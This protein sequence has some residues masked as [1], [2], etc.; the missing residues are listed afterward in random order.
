MSAKQQRRFS[1]LLSLAVLALVAIATLLTYL[2]PPAQAQTFP[3]FSGAWT[4]TRTQTG[5]VPP[6]LTATSNQTLTLFQTAPGGNVVG[7]LATY[8]P[9]TP[10][11]WTSYASGTITGSTMAFTFTPTVINLPGGTTACGESLSLAL[12]TGSVT[13]ATVPSYHP[14]GGTSSTFA[15]YPFTLLG[16]QKMYGTETSGCSGNCAYII[17]NSIDPATGNIVEPTVD[18]ETA[19]PNKLSL[20]R[21]YN[22]YHTPTRL[23]NF[24]SNIV[25]VVSGVANVTTNYDL[26]LSIVGN[27]ATAYRADGQMLTFNLIGGVW[28][29]DSDVDMVL[30]N[31]S[32]NTW[33]ITNHDDSVETYTATAAVL[34]TL[35]TSRLNSIKTRNG[36]TQTLAYNGSN[37]LSTVTDSYGRTLTFNYT[38]GYLTS[39]TTP[40]SLV[41]SYGYSSSTGGSNDR[42]AS[43]S[44]NTSPATSQSFTYGNSSFPFLI[45]SITD[46]N[47]VAYKTYTYD[48]YGRALTSQTGTGANADITTV[49]YNDSVGTSTVTNALGQS[50]VNTFAALQG[51]NKSAKATRTAS[52]N[53]PAATST[54][55]YDSNGY[56][57]TATDWNGNKTVYT[58]N[59]HGDPTTIVEASGTAAARTTTIAYDTTFVH[60]PATI[61]ATGLTTGFSYDANG[62][63]LTRVLTDTTTQTIPYSTNGQTRTTNF[64]WNNFLPATV[65][66]PNGNTTTFTFAPDGALT[67]IQNALLQNAAITSHTGGGMPLTV[68]GQNGVTTTL[69][70]NQRNWLLTSTVST[71][72][73]PL[74]TTNSYDAVGNLTKVQQPDGSYLN[75]AYDTAYRLTTVTDSL[76]NSI[77]Y[78]LDAMGD[79]T[80]TAIKDPS[81]TLTRSL[82]ATFDTLGRA[83]TSVAGMSQTTTWQYDDNGNMTG[84]LPPARHFGYLY[85]QLDRATRM[86]FYSIS[87]YN[88]AAYDAQDNVT[89]RTDTLSKTTSYVFDGFGDRIQVT[90]PDT[91][92]AVYHYDSD[93]N[94]TQK[95]DAAGV[96]V[97]HTYDALD[98]LLTTTYPAS[99]GENVTHTYD[100]T[101]TGFTFGIGRLTSLTDQAGT[102][103]QAYDERGNLLTETRTSGATT[104]TT[105]YTYDAASRV[106]TITYPDTSVVTYTRDAMGKITSVTDK[107][108]GAGSPTTLASSITYKP[109]GPWSGFTYGNGIVETPT[110][111]AD[112][113]LTRLADAGTATVQDI[114]YVYSVNDQP[115]TATDNLTAGNSITNITDDPYGHINAYR[116]NGGTLTQIIY[117]TS[118]NVNNGSRKQITGTTYTNTSGTNQLATITTGGVTNTLTTSANGNITGFST[119]FGTAGVTTLAY[120]NANRLSSVSNSGGTLGSY[121]YEASG[122]RFSKTVGANTT[123]FTHAG[124]AVLAETAGGTATNYIYL[125][126]R[127]LAML[128]GSTFTYL[129][130]DNLGTPRVATNASQTVSWKASYLPFG[131]TLSTT[132]SLTQNLRFPGQYFDAESGFN[133]NGFRDYVPTL[134]RYLEA[135]PIGIYPNAGI[136]NAGMNPYIYVGADPMR[137]IDPWGLAD[138]G[139]TF[140]GTCFESALRPHESQHRVLHPGP[141]TPIELFEAYQECGGGGAGSDCGI[142]PLIPAET[143]AL[144]QLLQLLNPGVGT[145]AKKVLPNSDP[146]GTATVYM[147]KDN[148]NTHFVISVTN[149]DETVTT[150][151][152]MTGNSTTIEL[153]TPPAGDVP[154]KTIDLPDAAGAQQ[155]QQSLRGAETGP[156]NPDTNSCL[157]HCGSVLTNGGV[158]DVPD[159]TKDVGRWLRRQP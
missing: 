31:P 104:L 110:R 134:G 41:L 99:T 147:T 105:G 133:H 137:T 152:V 46:E 13:T 19:G 45:T 28:T 129:H 55:V 37:Q 148:G 9:G 36:Y 97:N 42:I 114:S 103:T 153:T 32:G 119:G 81:G 33:T 76:G 57:A 143:E 87:G 117:D 92:T 158:P 23:T 144:L 154:S 132:G 124:S 14:C 70:Y 72:A 24:V 49:T 89:S 77:N 131:E 50:V 40:D 116:I 112:Y 35:G 107:P 53:V 125:N 155:Y 17:T 135:D 79:R 130:D 21:Y 83:L 128:T 156:Y 109:F 30:A 27:T 48:S 94:L 20:V 98:R 159:N 22:G 5:L 106:A 118:V 85:D 62:N 149:G 71:T 108:A 102:L 74:T 96:T 64:T 151:Q 140:K 141:C 8:W 34:P 63:P 56:A 44:Y 93:G 69:T 88:Y 122:N 47:G 59:S 115:N 66:S 60:L 65:Q 157:T 120:N 7:T 127:P 15:S 78:T 101:G 95:V 84:Y 67:N 100:Q 6:G 1:I 86:T 26:G 113:R 90:N 39:V 123:L 43:V 25:Y 142:N 54:T 139:Y 145:A 82:S 121:V 11:Y 2:A 75:N 68:V 136:V 29:P 3:N 146:S 126:G 73:G 16:W 4:G 111:D 138:A 80:A 18:Y 52:T 51:R 61:T 12:A 38:L 91:G 58:N 150:H 10:Y